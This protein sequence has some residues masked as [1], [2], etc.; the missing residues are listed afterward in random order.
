MI[1]DIGHAM[2]KLKLDA[3]FFLTPNRTIVN[4][5]DD[6]VVRGYIIRLS[7]GIAP[8]GPR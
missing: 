3:D 2:A 7:R 4:R 5:C 1:T 6:S 8:N